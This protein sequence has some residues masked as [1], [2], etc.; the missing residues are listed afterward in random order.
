MSASNNDSK[1]ID[2][3]EK[4]LN[5]AET[6]RDEDARIAFL[7]GYREGLLR[8]FGIASGSFTELLKVVDEQANDEGLWFIDG[9]EMEQHLQQELRRLHGVIEFEVR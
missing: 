1:W 8:A 5:L 2:A 6:M 9:T 7:S 4:D 3:L